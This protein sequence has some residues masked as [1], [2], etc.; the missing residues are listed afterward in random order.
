MAAVDLHLPEGWSAA[1]RRA[2]TQA[3]CQA[4]N[5]A[6]QVSP[7]AVRIY[8]NGRAVDTD[9]GSRTVEKPAQGLQEVLEATRYYGI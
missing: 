2:A 9:L 8:I 4:L 6:L 5:V 1:Q 3:I 7:G